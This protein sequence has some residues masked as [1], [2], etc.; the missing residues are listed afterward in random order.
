M[1]ENLGRAILE[2]T[3]DDSQFDE[4]L[5]RDKSKAVAFVAEVKKI[6]SEVKI[7]LDEGTLSQSV[8]QAQASLKSM[9]NVI[10]EDGTV[11][12]S[13]RFETTSAA[14]ALTLLA[15]AKSSLMQTTSALKNQLLEENNAQKQAITGMKAD[16]YQKT[17]E[18]KRQLATETATLKNHL[19]E[20]KAAG[21][22]AGHGLEGLKN[23]AQAS[24]NG[25][26]SLISVAS[27]AA[28]GLAHLGETAAEA[29]ATGLGKLASATRTAVADLTKLAAAGGAAFGALGVAGVKSASSLEESVNN[30][31]SIADVNKEQVFS[32]LNEMTT[33]VPQSAAQLG[34]SLYNVFSSFSTNQEQALK[35]TEGFAKGAV[36][37][38]TDAQTFGTSVMGV[39]NAYG[40]S[41]DEAGHVQD[42]FFQTVKNGVVNGKE[43]A[44]GLGP[45]TQAAKAAGVNFDSLGAMIAG[46]TKEGGPAAQNIN[47]LNNFLQK[48]TTKEAQSQLTQLGIK[49]KDAAGNFRPVIDVL[50]DLKGSLSKM[51]E[52]QRANALQAIFPDAQARQG[53]ATLMSQLD[54]V[55][56]FLKDNIASSGAAEAAY[57]KMVSGFGA[58]TKLLLNSLKSMLTTVGGALLPVLTPVVTGLTKQLNSLKPEVDKFAKGLASGLQQGINEATRVLSTAKDW[59]KAVGQAID[60]I[61]GKSKDLFL[62]SGVINEVFGPGVGDK[63]GGF[64]SQIG[65]KFGPLISKV[66]ELYKA[67]SPLSNALSIFQ[68]LL[69]G[70][71]GGALDAFGGAVFRISQELGFNTTEGVQIA[72]S[73]VN[74]LKSVFNGL[75]STVSDL[76]RGLGSLVSSIAKV[77]VESDLLGSGFRIIQTVLGTVSTVINTLASGIKNNLG[78]ITSAAKAVG[79]AF[80][81][82]FSLAKN[83]VTF[84][85]TLISDNMGTIATV[86]K[87]VA[88][89]V[90]QNLTILGQVFD[91][92]KP[93]ISALVAGVLH[94]ADVITTEWNK[95][96]ADNKP[97]VDGVVAAIGFLANVFATGIGP[98]IDIALIPVKL[99]FETI[100]AGGKTIDAVMKGDLVAASQAAAQGADQLANTVTTGLNPALKSVTDAAKGGGQGISDWGNSTIAAQTAAQNIN[101][102][103][104]QMAS[105]HD[106]LASAVSHVTG[107]ID[108]LRDATNQA[109]AEMNQTQSS[110]NTLQS[111]VGR[112][113]RRS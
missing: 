66:I 65:D 72:T 88:D 80:E 1:A 101:P 86:V 71:V 89:I 21:D 13:L 22:Q 103:L 50:G 90:K 78:S 83:V 28:S 70:G 12:Q 99:F 38:Q 26:H 4:G 112:F 18:L 20:E 60:G 8:Q 91:S 31:G 14:N 104:A 87:N 51:T 98:A 27:S 32:A 47:N 59:P 69:K 40:Q 61:T 106:T 39:L 111:M 96:L 77:V 5:K 67:F 45:V 74:G 79:S 85:A 113:V 15:Q 24:L 42:V 53:A 6:F 52:A 30:I 68:G 75:K 2:I 108:R 11:M 56:G 54:N 97:T 63:V 49:T 16:E 48:V 44:E 110:M 10:K 3:T 37:A 92:L 84:V 25:L 81:T 93:A 82:G 33:R 35:A 43:L 95:A 107:E 9:T 19:M 23:A 36:A 7:R 29:A 64:I 55:K 105:Q 46:V 94:A 34:D 57:Q 58:Q 102:V 100:S 109:S 76:M 17:A 73:A 62:F 41:L